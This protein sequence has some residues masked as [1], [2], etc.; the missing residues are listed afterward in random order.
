MRDA[1]IEFKESLINFESKGESGSVKIAQAC[2][3]E[4]FK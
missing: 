4:N 2:A 1:K 3:R